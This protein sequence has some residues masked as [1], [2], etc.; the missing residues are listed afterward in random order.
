MDIRTHLPAS[1]SGPAERRYNVDC[2]SCHKVM[3]GEEECVTCCDAICLECAVRC[4]KCGAGK[5]YRCMT[6]ALKNGYALNA[7]DSQW[8]CEECFE[9]PEL[10]SPS[11]PI[12]EEKD[13][14]IA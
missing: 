14:T 4:S 10:F 3:G 5:D 12:H 9:E 13:E 2:S 8:Y 7:D 1:A 11:V 6:C